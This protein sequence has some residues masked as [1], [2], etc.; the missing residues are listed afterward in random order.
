VPRQPARARSFKIAPERLS[1]SLQW[2]HNG[3]PPD[4]ELELV[5]D[6]TLQ[7][8]LVATL[9]LGALTRHS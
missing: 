7:F 8:D 2:L 5:R 4:F 1:F 9:L 3:S 6:S